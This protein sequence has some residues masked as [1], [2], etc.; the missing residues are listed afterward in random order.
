MKQLHLAIHLR[1]CL[2]RV[3]RHRYATHQSPTSSF[4]DSI[5]LVARQNAYVQEI[6]VPFVSLS[7]I[8]R[9]V[10]FPISCRTVSFFLRLLLS[11]LQCL[12]N[13]HLCL[14]LM[15]AIGR[16]QHVLHH[17]DPESISVIS[18]TVSDWLAASQ[19]EYHFEAALGNMGVSRVSWDSGIC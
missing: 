15:P 11:L 18:W 14:E 16:L 5:D 12:P 1:K 10:C 17:T 3:R 4:I 13:R 6:M 7:F 8:L 19:Q 2:Y 9:P